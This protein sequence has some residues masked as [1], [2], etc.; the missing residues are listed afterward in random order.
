MFQGQIGEIPLL[1]PGKL[2]LF[3]FSPYF[4]TRSSQQLGSLTH[5]KTTFS[6]R[7][8]KGYLVKKFCLDK[9]FKITVSI[10][11]CKGLFSITF[12]AKSH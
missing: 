1:T 10:S 9:K 5:L 8:G 11:N 7:Y 2:G 12:F 4:S 6:N 3:S